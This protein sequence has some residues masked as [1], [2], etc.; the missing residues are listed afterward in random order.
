MKEKGTYM[1]EEL[2]RLRLAGTFA[3]NRFKEFYPQQRLHLDHI[4]D[5]DQKVVS[6]LKY[7]L[8]VKD[9]SLSNVLDDFSDS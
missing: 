6:T 8:I 7:L 4:P 3:R 1:L 9:G 2:D 5:L